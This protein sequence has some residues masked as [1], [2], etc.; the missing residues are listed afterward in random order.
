MLGEQPTLDISY[1]PNESKLKDGKYTKQDVP[2]AATVKIGEENVNGYTAFLHQNC[3]PDCGWAAPTTPNGDPAFLIH[4]QTCTLKITK[5]GGADGEP[6]VFDI[7]KDNVKYSEVT[8]K[9]NGSE[10]IEELPVGEYTI[11][12]DTGWSWRFNPNPN[13]SGKVILSKDNTS[14]TITCTNTKNNDQWL[15]GFSDVVKNIFDGSHNN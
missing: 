4:I 5:Q 13:Y 9:G 12:E 11:E 10:N 6:Y 2:V 14:G 7:Y 8:V 15:N 3:T 1:T